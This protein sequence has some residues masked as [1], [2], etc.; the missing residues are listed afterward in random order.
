MASSH[1]PSGPA[2]STE[3]SAEA[4]AAASGRGAADDLVVLERDLGIARIAL[5]R[6]DKLNSFSRQMHLALREAIN[7]ARDDAEVRVIVLEGRG[8][9]F[10]AGQDLSDL[11][12]EPGRVSDLGELVE[13]LFN[14]LIRQIKACPKPILAKVHGIAAGAGASLAMA[15]DLTVASKSAAFLQAFVN[16]GLLPDSGGT[17]FL[18][19]LAGSQRAMALAMLGEKLPAPVAAQ[20]GLIWQCVEDEELE[21]FVDRTAA[22]LAALPSLALKACKYAILQAASNTLSEQLDLERDAQQFLGQ[23]EDYLEGVHAFLEKRKAHFT[24]R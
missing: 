9:G 18:Q 17:W 23:S 3:A 4:S 22:R 16:I 2:G 19:R 5:N 10:C 15:C 7:I 12:F 6:P 13:S 8:R 1:T 21:A 14:P 24:G 11:S 20:W